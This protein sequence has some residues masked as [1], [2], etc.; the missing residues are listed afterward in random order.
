[1]EW[2]MLWRESIE[3][4]VNKTRGRLFDLPHSFIWIY[5]RNPAMKVTIG[6]LSMDNTVVNEK[7][8]DA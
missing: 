1:M 7:I 2:W 4:G 8:S 5:N 6:I 3:S